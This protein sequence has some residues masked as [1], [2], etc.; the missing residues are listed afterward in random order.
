MIG[1]IGTKLY[2]ICPLTSGRFFVRFMLE[3]K[4]TSKY[5]GDRNT[6]VLM[7]ADAQKH[8]DLLPWHNL[9]H[10]LTFFR[11]ST[12]SIVLPKFCFKCCFFMCG[13]CT[14]TLQLKKGTMRFG[15]FSANVEVQR[16]GW[17]TLQQTKI[18]SA[19][20]LQMQTNKVNGLFLNEH[21][22]SSRAASVSPLMQH[23]ERQC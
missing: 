15:S 2:L 13:S 4:G 8:I 10:E 3:S 9:H 12:A 1:Y 19:T 22:T 7:Q 23:L 5:C 16:L 14:P 21:R 18:C 17:D 6:S 11:F 20:I